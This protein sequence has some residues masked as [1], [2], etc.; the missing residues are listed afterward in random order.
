[1]KTLLVT[2]LLIS[3]ATI[4]GVDEMDKTSCLNVSYRQSYNNTA[5]SLCAVNGDV[6]SLSQDRLTKDAAKLLAYLET[7]SCF[8]RLDAHEIAN[9]AKAG[10]IEAIAKYSKSDCE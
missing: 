7:T 8:D 4:A 3:T 9:A 1:M 6:G 10:A 2:L 5:K